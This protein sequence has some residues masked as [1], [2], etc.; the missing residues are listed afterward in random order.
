MAEE[1]CARLRLSTR[2]ERVVELVRHHLRFKDLPLKAVNPDAVLALEGF[3][4]HLNCIV[5]IVFPATK[6]F[7][8]RSAKRR[9]R[10]RR[11]KS[12]NLRRSS[13]VRT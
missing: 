13:G 3:E 11:Q 7:E 4:E 8:L 6:S 10:K 12:S 1:T 5:S 9:W 2:V